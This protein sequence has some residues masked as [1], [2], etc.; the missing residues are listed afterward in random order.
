MKINSLFNFKIQKSNLRALLPPVNG[1]GSEQN[2]K[3]PQV[4]IS[5]GLALIQTHQPALSSW[6][7]A[8]ASPL[9]PALLPA[10]RKHLFVLFYFDKTIQKSYRATF[11]SRSASQEPT[12]EWRGCSRVQ[13]S[14]WQHHTDMLHV[15]GKTW[16]NC[17]MKIKRN[18]GHD[19]RTLALHSTFI[20]STHVLFSVSTNRC[21]IKRKRPES[22]INKSPVVV[23]MMMMHH[24]DRADGVCLDL[25]WFWTFWHE[26]CCSST[27]TL[28]RILLR[29]RKQTDAHV[30]GWRSL[31]IKLQVL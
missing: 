21:P 4:F 15:F 24:V 8:L 2:P 6:A 20:L 10:L 26:T 12:K 13:T 30:T 19:V 5:E 17:W 23:M 18:F 22:W 29:R 3:G 14:L 11:W 31:S 1:S 16:K 7:L 9:H 27:T 25:L 28:Y